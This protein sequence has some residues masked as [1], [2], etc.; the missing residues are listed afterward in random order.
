MAP[1]RFSSGTAVAALTLCFAACS[2]AGVPCAGDPHHQV[3][4]SWQCSQPCANIDVMPTCSC[5]D[6]GTISAVG[7]ESV[8]ESDDLGMS[9]EQAAEQATEE[10]VVRMAVGVTL[11][12]FF[13]CAAICFF[14]C[15]KGGSDKAST[16]VREMEEAEE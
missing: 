8:G 11:L 5:N 2:V 13:A 3:G 6:D 14:L 10:T 4:D 9:A 7:C 1:S 15:V 12:C 16:L